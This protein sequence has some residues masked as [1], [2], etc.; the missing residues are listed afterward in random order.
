MF[1]QKILKGISGLTPD[2]ATEILTVTG[3]ES[4]WIR[5]RGNAS[6][7]QIAERLTREELQWHLT[8]YDETDTRTGK[9]F[10]GTSPFISTTSG[11]SEQSSIA[12]EERAYVFSAF[13]CAAWFA[14]LD[15]SQSGWIFY[16]YVFTIGRPSVKH[17]E[18][19]EE[20]RDL[21]SY[22]S[23]Y[24]FHREGE[25]VAKLVVPPSRLERCEFYRGPELRRA[26]EAGKRPALKGKDIVWN[27]NNYADPMNYVNIRDAL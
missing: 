19:A 15:Y 4:N 10:G 17:A 24:R 12:D 3:I 23:G 5:T 11:T 1:F 2:Q 9:P 27:R 20:V 26:L 8:R 16:G 22:P 13:D 6:Q 14:T 25:L 7:Q 18:F 21:H